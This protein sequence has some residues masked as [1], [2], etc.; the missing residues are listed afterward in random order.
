MVAVNK[1][2]RQSMLTVVAQKF[3]TS[4]TV[5]AGGDGPTAQL[6]SLCVMEKKC[7]QQISPY[8]DLV[9]SDII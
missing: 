2:V 7:Q 6:T 1:S 3:P 4:F 9:N 8:I 5:N